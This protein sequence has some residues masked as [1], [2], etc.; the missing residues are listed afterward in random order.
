MCN[1]IIQFMNIKLVSVGKT[2]DKALEMLIQNYIKRLTR[3]INFEFI[4]VPDLKN[5]KNSPVEKQKQQEGNLLLV[6]FDKSDFVILLDEKGTQFSSIG[7]STF[8]QK[9]MLSGIKRLVFVIGGPYGFSNAVY[10]RANQKISL[11]KMTFSHQMV[12]LFFVEQL[13]RAFTIIRNEPYHHE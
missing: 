10:Q 9:K 1:Y 13:Y 12:R 7:F 11:S 2:D 3:Y 5:R 6:H 8:I 4:V